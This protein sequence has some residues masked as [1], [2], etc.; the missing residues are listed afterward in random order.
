MEQAQKLAEYSKD[1]MISVNR[2]CFQN[3][4]MEESDNF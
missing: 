1:L 2:N 4:N 3:R